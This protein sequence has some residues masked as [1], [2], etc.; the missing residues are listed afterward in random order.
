MALTLNDVRTLQ[1]TREF[2]ESF[3]SD[4]GIPYDEY[5]RECR[6]FISM[7]IKVDLTSTVDSAAAVKAR[8]SQRYSLISEFIEKRR[9]LVRE[10]IKSDG[11]MD[12]QA[13]T[14]A[15]IDDI[16]GV[17]IL[18]EAFENEDIDEIQINDPFSIFVV[19]RGVMKPYMD[20]HGKYYSFG[21]DEEVQ[22][23]IARL[24]DD[25]TGNAPQFTAGNPI[26]NASS[27]KERYRINAVHNVANARDVAPNDFP[28]SSVV[29]RKF[30]KS[31]LVMGDLIRT[32]SVTEKEAQFI[33]LLGKAGLKVF[34]VGP[35][36]SGKTTL[37]NIIGNDLPMNKRVV[38]VQNPTEIT[39]FDRD[40]KRNRRNVLHWEV[41]DFSN[42]EDGVSATMPNEISNTLR[43]TPDIII[44]GEARTKAEF[45][46]IMRELKM[47][48]PVLGTFHAEGAED[49]AERFAEELD[50]GSMQSLRKVAK[51]LDIIIAQYR[52]PD[53]TRRVMEVSELRGLKSDGNVDVNTLFRYKLTG[54]VRINPLNG[55]DSPVG[56]HEQVG[57][58][59]E[60]LVD[61]FYKNGVS[62]QALSPFM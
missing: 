11:L 15:L 42:K 23:L 5:L 10:Y 57:K 46:Q 13:L 7:N 20:K 1:S 59:S 33:H 18:R 19:E 26:L 36:G 40:K 4:S 21:N 22:L 17:G 44:V 61:S 38:L 39:L 3:G 9:V 35:T 50:G 41:S 49:G 32:G 51:N 48:Q 31:H 34:C 53:G 54:E 56:I 62:K 12:K 52:F 8:L 24:T 2:S 37:L 27:A 60:R 28:G 16:T 45:E 29:I 55:L 43:V 25:G 58:I 14:T 47:G 30:K 6:N